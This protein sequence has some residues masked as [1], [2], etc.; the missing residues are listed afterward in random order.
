MIEQAADISAEDRALIET[1]RSEI[2]ALDYTP[3]DDTA[4]IEMHV[5]TEDAVED[6]ESEGVHRTPDIAAFH[7]M[8]IEERAPQAVRDLAVSRYAEAIAAKARAAEA[9]TG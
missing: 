9:V 3:L 8:L 2:R 5:A 6:A 1:I 4:L 7:A